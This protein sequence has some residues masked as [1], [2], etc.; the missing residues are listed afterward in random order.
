MLKGEITKNQLK[1]DTKTH[2]SQPTKLVTW[3]IRSKWPHKMQ[4]E[5]NY[6]A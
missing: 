6:E 1:K 5:I 4:T 3:V 2:L